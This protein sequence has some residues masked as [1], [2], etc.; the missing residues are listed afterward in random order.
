[1]ASPP[2]RKLDG[3]VDAPDVNHGEAHQYGEQDPAHALG[4]GVAQPAAPTADAAEEVGAQHAKDGHGDELKG[5]AGHHDVRALVLLL[6]GVGARGLG[7]ADGLD[8][9]RDQVAQAK[10][11]GVKPGRDNGGLRP[12]VDDQA[13]QEDVQGRR[14]E[15][16]GDDQGD[17]LRDEGVTIVGTAGGVETR[18]PANDF[19]YCGGENK[20]ISISPLLSPGEGREEV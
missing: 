19:G 17:D 8:D 7:A 5:D 1:M 2:L 11:D 14:E 18:G 20:V 6:L 15:D 9:E 10:D 4:D 3:P 16:G 12:E 13:A